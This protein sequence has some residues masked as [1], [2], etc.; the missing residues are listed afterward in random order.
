MH[1]KFIS[2]KTKKK[3]KVFLFFILL[4]STFFFSLF[5]FAKVFSNKEFI[6]VLVNMNFGSKK[7]KESHNII[8]YLLMVTLNFREKD[9]E[10]TESSLEGYTPD[11]EPS[12]NKEN[13]LIYIYN[14]HQGESYD[15]GNLNMGDLT[16]NVMLASYRMRELLNKKNFNTLVETNK[17]S[18]ILKVKGWDYTRS[19]DASRILLKDALNNHPSL[20]YFFDIHRDSISYEASTLVSYNKK[21]AK[22]L[23]VIGTDYKDYEDNH[24]LAQKISDKMNENVK[25]ISKGILKKGGKGV[26]GIYN[27]DFSKTTLLFEIGSS[28][29][30]IEEVDNTIEVLTSSIISVV[31]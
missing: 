5:Y 24:E 8:D 11:P 14:T 18:A 1:K 26:N 31:N 12:E 25:G 6:H 9:E 16:P 20:K 2:H 13:P 19:Y 21:Y 30:S 10:V 22:I 29:N 27:E 17:V 23:F 7:N 15:G 28:Y 4:M 3:R